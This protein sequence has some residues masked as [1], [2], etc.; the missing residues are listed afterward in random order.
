[1][2]T[3]LLCIALGREAVFS[4]SMKYLEKSDKTIFGFMHPFFRI[5][6]EIQR[7]HQPGMSDVMELWGASCSLRERLEIFWSIGDSFLYPP[8]KDELDMGMVCK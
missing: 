2:S 5:L 6:A 7:L 1:M 4:S 8:E 3:S